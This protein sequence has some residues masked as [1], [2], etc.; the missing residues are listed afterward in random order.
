MPRD[1][2]HLFDANIFYPEPRTLAYSDHLIVEGMMLPFM[3]PYLAVSRDA[4]LTRSLAEVAL[5]S[6]RATDYLATGGRFHLALWSYRFFR[7]DA[8]F[9]GIAALALVLVAMASGVAYDRHLDA[10]ASFPDRASI[11]CLRGQGVTHAVGF[12]FVATAAAS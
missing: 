12:H 6:A 1:P 5:H 9:P 7:A 2:L 4:G 10:L 8:L 11:D 3:L